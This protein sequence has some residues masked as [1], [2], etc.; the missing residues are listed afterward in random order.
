MQCGTTLITFF[1]F[2][3]HS[4]QPHIFIHASV[5]KRLRNEQLFRSNEVKKGEKLFIIFVCCF[6]LH[7][8]HTQPQ[9][10]IRE[11]LIN[12]KRA[13]VLEGEERKCWC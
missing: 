2:F 13:S 10:V 12:W 5:I 9:I 3:W 11:K 7:I 4:T 1:I 8:K 6:Q